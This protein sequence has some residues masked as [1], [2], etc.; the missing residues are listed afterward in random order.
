MAATYLKWKYPSPL[1]ST[2][3]LSEDPTLNF[4]IDIVDVYSL[5]SMARIMRSSDS[6]SPLEALVLQGFLGNAPLNPSI[7]VS[8]KTLELYRRIR[9]RK[10]SFSVE[11]F[12]KVIYDL[13][14]V[15]CAW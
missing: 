10:S 4:D 9:M 2:T 1:A 8:I 7:A 15:P 3:P 6:K 11:A 12:A 13:Y 14:A 5:D